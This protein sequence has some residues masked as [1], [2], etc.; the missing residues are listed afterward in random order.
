[1][2]KISSTSSFVSLSVCVVPASYGSTTIHSSISLSHD[3]AGHGSALFT[4]IVQVLASYTPLF[5]RF[6]ILLCIVLCASATEIRSAELRAG[7]LL[8]SRL[9]QLC[10]LEMP[11]LRKGSTNRIYPY[12]PGVGFAVGSDERLA[13]RRREAA[14][15]KAF[16]RQHPGILPPNVGT[17]EGRMFGNSQSTGQMNGFGGLRQRPGF[18]GSEGGSQEDPTAALPRQ[19]SRSQQYSPS[20][21][22]ASCGPA[23]GRQRQCFSPGGGFQG[24][25]ARSR[26]G[27]WPFVG[28]DILAELDRLRQPEDNYLGAYGGL[29]PR[30]FPHCFNDY[31]S[32]G[33]DPQQHELFSNRDFYGCGATRANGPFQGEFNGQ[34]DR[35]GQFTPFPDGAPPHSWRGSTRD[36]YER[37]RPEDL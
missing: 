36:S 12:G 34:P 32:D 6:V 22:A 13:A 27:L 33:I 15:M 18:A 4:L 5:T 7:T 10:L 31:Q 19:L 25:V 3:Y 26:G 2:F 14:Q 8:S 9:N 21:F 1:M 11:F 17:I 16:M 30:R 20:V 24:D 29:G 23:F 37:L 28:E 35:G